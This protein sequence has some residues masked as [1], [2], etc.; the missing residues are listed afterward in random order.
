MN[1]SGGMMRWVIVGVAALIA[2]AV[3]KNFDGP[4]VHIG[5]TLL[6]AYLAYMHTSNM[7]G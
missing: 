2:W 5:V 3:S 6:V 1:M 7:G 4:M